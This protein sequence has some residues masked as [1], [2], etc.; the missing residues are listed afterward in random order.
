MYKLPVVAKKA[1]STSSLYVGSTIINPNVKSILRCLAI[2]L[3]RNMSF[4]PADVESMMKHS[5]FCYFCE[6]KYVIENPEMTELSAVAS[7]PPT[8]ESIA[9]FIGALFDSAQFSPESCIISVMYVMRLL[10]VNPGMSLHSSNWRPLVLTGLI[11]AQKV[12]DD[13][14]LSNADFATIYPFFSVYEINK[15]EQKFLELLKYQITVKPASYMN[16]YCYLRSLDKDNAVT[17]SMRSR[18]SF[19]FGR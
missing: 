16:Y 15:L 5:Q 10:L 1:S 4:K 11:I 12:W 8:V 14:Y 3:S 2:S 17:L 6:E 18:R 7:T 9:T 13:R 19:R